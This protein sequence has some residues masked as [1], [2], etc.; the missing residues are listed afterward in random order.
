M[1]ASKW[2]KIEMTLNERNWHYEEKSRKPM[3]P[4]EFYGK[5]LPTKARN[6]NDWNSDERRY[7]E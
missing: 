6:D 3:L 4:S 7:Q 5:K 1:K 2:A